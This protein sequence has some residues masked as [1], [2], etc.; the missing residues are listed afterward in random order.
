MGYNSWE[1]KNFFFLGL[2]RLVR[3]ALP[4]TLHGVF[5]QENRQLATRRT[6]LRSSHGTVGDGDDRRRNGAGRGDVAGLFTTW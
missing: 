1:C 2:W 5:E 4:L 3:K 6:A